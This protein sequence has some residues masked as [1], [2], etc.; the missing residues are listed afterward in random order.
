[1]EG[2]AFE[3]E[4]HRNWTDASFKTYVRP[5]ALPW[6]YV[7]PK[8]KPV[9]Q[10]VTLSFSGKL[11]RPRAQGRSKPVEVA[12]G[13]PSRRHAAPCRRRRRGGHVDGAR[14]CCAHQGGRRSSPDLHARCGRLRPAPVGRRHSRTARPHRCRDRARGRRSRQ[15]GAGARARVPRRGGRGVGPSP[16]IRPRVARHRSEGGSA[17][18][19]RRRCA[20]PE[21]HPRRGPQGVSG[22]E[23][24]RRHAILL[25]RAQSQAAAGRLAST[26]SPTR[27]A[28]SSMPPTTYPSWR[29]S[30]RFPMS[31]AR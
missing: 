22:S 17:G 4:D 30:R 2:D 10:S 8:G 18:K 5:L 16:R 14:P 1:M 12:L 28:R 7:L 15:G 26:S 19:R 20:R 6:P 31:C 9:T 3:T 11:P 23:G 13:R 24:G 21:G 29:R 27:P 25:H